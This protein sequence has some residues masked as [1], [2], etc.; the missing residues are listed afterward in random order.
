M[1]AA[2][3][4]R[5]RLACP[6]TASYP[7]DEPGPQDGEGVGLG[8][9]V[10][11]GVGVA[12]GSGVGVGAGVGV[13][14]GEGVRAGQNGSDGSRRHASSRDTTTDFTFPHA[15]TLN[16]SAAMAMAFFIFH[17]PITLTILSTVRFQAP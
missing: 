8:D 10:G 7:S 6:G 16:A 9:G 14:V 12:D 17:P 15:M 2:L 11:A 1:I 4:S 13:G 3:T 5:L